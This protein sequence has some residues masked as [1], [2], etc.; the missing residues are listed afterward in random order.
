MY[1]GFLTDKA[2]LINGNLQTI[3]RYI[4][5]VYN[6]VVRLKIASKILGILSLRSL[7]VIRY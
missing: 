7:K 1:P 3:Y 6:V 5:D 2:V 4:Y